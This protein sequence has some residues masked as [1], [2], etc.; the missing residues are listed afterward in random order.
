V[1][2]SDNQYHMNQECSWAVGLHRFSRFSM[3]HS[4]SITLNYAL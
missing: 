3:F 1:V 2:V 4:Q